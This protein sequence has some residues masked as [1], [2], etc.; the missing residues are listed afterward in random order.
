MVEMEGALEMS[1]S[2]PFHLCGKECDG[3]FKH[4]GS[5]S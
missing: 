4:L 1:W 2:L 3:V 5:D